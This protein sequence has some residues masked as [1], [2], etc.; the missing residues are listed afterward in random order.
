MVLVHG[1]T[2]T[3]GSWGPVADQLGRRHRVVAVDAPGHGGSATIA[4]D[5]P[6]GGR[7]LGRLGPATFVG[8]SM[9]GRFGL[10]AALAQ[11]ERVTRLVLVSTTAGIEDD[12]ERAARRASDELLA[13]RVADEGVAGFVEWWLS[14]PLFATLPATAAGRD[15]RLVNTAAGLAS[16]LR[17][18]GAGTQEPLWN[19]LGQLTMPVLIVTGALDTRYTEVGRRMAGIIGSNA[20]HRVIGGAGHA[21]HLECPAD[22]LDIVEPFL[23]QPSPLG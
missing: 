16:S 10:H 23:D 2:Q 5:L 6:T 1:F 15:A 14:T 12:D 3:G 22:F 9:G 19:R 7:L 17:L 20:E 4:A 21:C 11:P 8:Y 13:R 18:A